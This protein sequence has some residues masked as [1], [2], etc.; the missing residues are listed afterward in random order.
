[1]FSC[2]ALVNMFEPVFSYVKTTT[3]YELQRTYVYP[4]LRHVQPPTC[5]HPADGTSTVTHGTPVAHCP[6]RTKLGRTLCLSMQRL[7]IAFPMMTVEASTA[8]T[9]GGIFSP[10]PLLIVRSCW[11][12]LANF[13]IPSRIEEAEKNC[14]GRRPGIIDQLLRSGTGMYLIQSTWEAVERETKLDPQLVVIDFCNANRHRSVGK[15]TIMSAMCVEKGVEHG[16]LLLMA[17]ITG[18]TCSAEAHAPVVA[19]WAQEG[20]PAWQNVL[21]MAASPDEDYDT[22]DS[23][24]NEK[25]PLS[26]TWTQERYARDMDLSWKARIAEECSLM[27]EHQGEYAGPCSTIFDGGFPV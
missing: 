20:P 3:S 5:L 26:V 22:S 15:G 4:L 13:R 17:R 7:S 19:R 2:W 6:I 27:A 25:R 11:W 1:M 23:A 14:S 12:T 16:L 10:R 18:S 9:L 21:L 8:P 24:Y